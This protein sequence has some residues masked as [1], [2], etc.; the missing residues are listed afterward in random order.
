MFCV[1]T[2]L[3]TQIEFLRDTQKKYSNLAK[4]TRILSSHFY[5][6]VQTQVKIPYEC[7]ISVADPRRE[8]APLKNEKIYYL[9]L[10][11]VDCVYNNTT[12]TNVIQ[13]IQLTRQRMSP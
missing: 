6:I 10:R 11:T 5:H 8:R 1:S 9:F 7:V 13:L 12:V 4:L 2:E 3:E